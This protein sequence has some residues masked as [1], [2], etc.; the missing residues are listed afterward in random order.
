MKNFLSKKFLTLQLAF[1][2]N[3]FNF[4]TQNFAKA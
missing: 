4:V 2:K 3:G 1:P